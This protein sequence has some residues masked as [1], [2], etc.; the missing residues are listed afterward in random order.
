MCVSVC[1]SVFI[2]VRKHVQIRS[3]QWV[4]F[5][6]NCPACVYYYYYN[7]NEYLLLLLLFGT[8]SIK[9]IWDSLIRLD[10]LASESQGS[11][12]LC[13]P[14]PEITNSGPHT[15]ISSLGSRAGAQVSCVA[16][17][18]QSELAPQP[19]TPCSFPLQPDSHILLPPLKSLVILKST[20]SDILSVSCLRH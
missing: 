18:V 3:Q 8:E 19:P 12:C 17:T 4:L 16:S 11:S 15:G 10:C 9:G 1:L 2:C 14:N 7:D 20:Q 13:L 5:L 6:R